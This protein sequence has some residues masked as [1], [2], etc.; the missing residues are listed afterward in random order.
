MSKWGYCYRPVGPWSAPPVRSVNAVG[1][2]KK[3]YSQPV[4]RW[5]NRKFILGVSA[6]DSG[7]LSFVVFTVVLLLFTNRSVFLLTSNKQLHS[8]TSHQLFI[9]NIYDLINDTTKRRPRQFA[10]IY[11]VTRS[12]PPQSNSARSLN[13]TLIVRF[14]LRTEYIS[15]VLPHRNSRRSP[16]SG[17]HRALIG[18]GT[19]RGAHRALIGRGALRRAPS[20]HWSRRRTHQW[21]IVA[22]TDRLIHNSTTILL[23]SWLSCNQ[24][25]NDGSF[26]NKNV[27]SANLENVN[28]V[29]VNIYKNDYILT[30][31]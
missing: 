25:C 1:G 20:S 5:Y 24:L 28:Y 11:Q 10:K 31:I 19:H 15:P 2:G 29:K 30:I 18:R 9:Y 7:G 12:P 27:L 4:H 21:R 14:P 23:T 3:H 13:P 8:V 6:L 16:K 26:D 22:R 17:L